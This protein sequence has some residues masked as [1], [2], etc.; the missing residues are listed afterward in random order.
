M[1]AYNNGKIDG[2]YNK[3][4]MV[5][6]IEGKWK[7][8]GKKAKFTAADI[9]NAKS[10]LNDLKYLMGARK[11][12]RS[13]GIARIFKEQKVRMGDIIGKIDVELAKNP[14]NWGT[15]GKQ[16]A[17]KPQQLEKFWDEYMDERFFIANQRTNHDMDTYL[18]LL[19]RIWTVPTTAAD[20]N[21]K[22]FYALIKKV[23]QEWA[24][25]KRAAWK[26]PW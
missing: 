6:R 2:V 8:K 13:P 7:G 18:T 23:K 1:W 15:F 19:D 5:E 14:K 11:Y 22:D 25:E 26:K 24:N 21:R 9:D 16:P 20:Q 3:A 10:A 4:K 12:M 17:W